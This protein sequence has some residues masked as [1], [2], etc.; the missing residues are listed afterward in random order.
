MVKEQDKKKKRGHWQR[1]ACKSEII[2]LATRCEI[3]FAFYFHIT[4]YNA[5]LAKFLKW[6]PFTEELLLHQTKNLRA[7]T[8]PPEFVD[9]GPKLRVLIIAKWEWPETAKTGVSPK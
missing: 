3:I 5:T 6:M 1:R 7:R 9:D 8:V 2:I 4:K